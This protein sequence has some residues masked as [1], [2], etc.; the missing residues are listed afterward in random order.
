MPVSQESRHGA[1][2]ETDRGDINA[3]SSGPPLVP[4]VP[5]VEWT[6]G[7]SL[8]SWFNDSSSRAECLFPEMLGIQRVAHK[9]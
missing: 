3:G 6:P 9:W 2:W 1:G 7:T 5:E 8:G 4:R